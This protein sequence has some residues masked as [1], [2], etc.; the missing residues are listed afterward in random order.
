[1]GKP[2]DVGSVDLHMERFGAGRTRVAAAQSPWGLRHIQRLGSQS[3]GSVL[4][5]LHDWGIFA[6]T[7]LWSQAPSIS[8][9]LDSKLVLRA[10][11]S[12]T[13]FQVS[14]IQ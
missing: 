5:Q 13:F 1:M 7:N 14:V 4:S 10:K 2:R 12:M 9:E 8:D 3:L 6:G 11:L